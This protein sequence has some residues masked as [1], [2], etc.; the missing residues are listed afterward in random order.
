ME[1]N[2]LDKLFEQKLAG[3]S[4]TPSP[5]AW[6]DLEAMLDKKKKRG[7]F[8]YY[9]VAAAVV[10][11]FMVGMALYVNWS[12]SSLPVAGETETPIKNE[13][14]VKRQE[15]KEAEIEVSPKPDND[16]I[17]KH[18]EQELAKPQGEEAE[19]H[20]IDL[21]L[22][23]PVN[24]V[25][26]AITKP[27]VSEDIQDELQL[28]DEVG[29]E[30]E[31]SLAVAEEEENTTPTARKPIRII[32]KSSSKKHLENRVVILAKLDT[33]KK[34]MPDV[35]DILRFPGSLLADVRDAKDGLLNP[36]SEVQR[37]TKEKQSK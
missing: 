36:Q 2:R 37:T 22:R 16:P 26:L 20:A 18:S 14:D 12:D 3:H 17:A 1:S 5:D 29:I 33:T 28:I 11:L 25:P 6:G 32:Y 8:W 35:R 15:Q 27:E 7:A 4:S 23:K 21:E 13:V 31:E 9:K 10:I 30:T 34:R 24:P 19:T